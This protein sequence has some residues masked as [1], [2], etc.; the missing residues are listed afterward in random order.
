VIVG[1]LRSDCA[2]YEEGLAKAAQSNDELHRAM[3]VHIAN[4][5]VLSQPLSELQKTLPS[6]VDIPRCKTL[7]IHYGH[8]SGTVRLPLRV[9]EC[10]TVY[11]QPSAQPP[12]PCLSSKNNLNSF[13]LV[14]QSGPDNVNNDNVKRFRNSLYRTIALHKLS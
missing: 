11:R 7:S 1:E 14:S 10:G 6:P 2:K 5:R 8:Q 9:Q 12:N 3:E 13:F 4:L